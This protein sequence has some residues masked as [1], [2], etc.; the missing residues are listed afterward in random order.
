MGSAE[1]GR[2]RRKDEVRNGLSAS[3][4]EKGR[5]NEVRHGESP[6]TGGQAL[7][8]RR[9]RRRRAG[10]PPSSTWLRRDLPSYDY[11]MASRLSRDGGKGEPEEVISDPAYAE[12]TAGQVGE[13]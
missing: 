8:W 2:R 1:N 7:R 12:A 3:K 13:W 5:I 9:R 4:K 6:H 11:G 10:D